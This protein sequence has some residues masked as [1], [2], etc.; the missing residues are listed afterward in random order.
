[1]KEE[2]E[3][4][5]RREKRTGRLAL[6]AN[7]ARERHDLY[8]AGSDGSSVTSFAKLRELER[9]RDLA[10]ARLRRAQEAP[11]A[12]PE[13]QGGEPVPENGPFGPDDDP[14]LG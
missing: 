1:M 14:R 11:A 2:I 6:A 10:A 7:H 12:E 5:R 8:E 3:A 9:E 13:P 4:A